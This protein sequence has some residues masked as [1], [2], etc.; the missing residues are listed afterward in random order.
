MS[1]RTSI[2]VISRNE[3][4]RLGHTI[5]NLQETAPPGADIVVVDD[6][7]D[8]GSAAFLHGLQSIRL[9]RTDGIGVARARNAGARHSVGEML[10]FL[11]GHMRMGSGWWKRLAEVASEAAVG[12]AA[13]AVADMENPRAA[14]YGLTFTGADLEVGWLPRKRREEPYAVPILPGCCLAMR[15]EAFEQAGGFDEALTGSGSVDGEMSVRLWLLGYELCVAPDVAVEHLFRETFP[16]PVSWRMQLRNRLRIALAHFSAPRCAA[17][18]EA[19]RDY[20]DFEPALADVTSGAAL[21]ERRE[22]LR[23]RRVR[24][25]DWLF[26]RF[27]IDW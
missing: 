2:V 6:G 15:R 7:S 17:V 1:P 20:E 12:A 8:D 27:C 25:D 4:E 14:G 18:T 22:W 26:E 23:R 19:L 3:G 11:D 21:E 5:Q 10:I 9:L 24:S 13:P 16:Y